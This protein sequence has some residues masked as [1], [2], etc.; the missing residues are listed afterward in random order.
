[1]TSSISDPTRGR[2][3]ARAEINESWTLVPSPSAAA[4]PTVA[5]AADAE[6]EEINSVVNST[7]ESSTITRDYSLPSSFVGEGQR[8]SGEDCAEQKSMTSLV[9]SSNQSK[10]GQQQQK[11]EM[12]EG[13]DDSNNENTNIERVD[14]ADEEKEEEDD[15]DS[16]DQIALRISKETRPMMHLV[17]LLKEMDDGKGN[18]HAGNTDPKGKALASLIHEFENEIS[19]I[20]HRVKDEYLIMNGDQP[21]QQEQQELEQQQPPPLPPNWIALEDPASGDVYYANE[22]T[23]ECCCY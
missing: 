9:S 4:A 21:Q 3:D 15:A 16:T 19:L 5:A 7:A 22:A 13:R 10:M 11:Y 2:R 18:Y 1:M 17:R 12:S 23:G 20:E 8:S 14:D 6:A